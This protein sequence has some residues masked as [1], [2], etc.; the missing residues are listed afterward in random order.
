[1]HKGDFD[2]VLSECLRAILKVQLALHKEDLEFAEISPVK[3]V[4]FLDFGVLQGFRGVA[5][6]GLG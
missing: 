3:L 1:M 4:R 2:A 5:M 6:Q